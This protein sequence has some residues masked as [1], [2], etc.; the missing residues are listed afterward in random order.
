M[1]AI[2]IV[3]IPFVLGAIVGVVFVCWNPTRKERH[4]LKT[5][6]SY[7]LENIS[8]PVL[9]SICGFEMGVHESPCIERKQ[10]GEAE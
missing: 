10:S 2:L 1:E 4:I 6:N 7:K 8:P 3:L 9:C 5:T